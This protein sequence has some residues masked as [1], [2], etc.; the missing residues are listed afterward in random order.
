MRPSIF[1]AAAT[2][3]IFGFGLAQAHSLA[4][5][6][7]ASTASAAS[8]ATT[9]SDVVKKLRPDDEGLVVLLEKNKGSYY[10]RRDVEAF[11]TY[12]KLLE[13]GL[14]SKKPVS[15]TF[16]PTQLNILEVK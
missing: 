8:A 3:V 16:E 7:L 1:I 5:R 10:L 15:V 13:E 9:V 14:K 11:D 6:R 12:R 2:L 4:S